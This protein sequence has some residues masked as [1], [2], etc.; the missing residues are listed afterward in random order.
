MK[1]NK[2]NKTQK[3]D[4]SALEEIYEQYS[5]MVNQIVYRLT[6]DKEETRDIVQ[7]IF[8]KIFTKISSFK[9]RSHLK[10]WISRVAVNTVY[11][12]FR[13]KRYRRYLSFEG[14]A[15]SKKETVRKKVIQSEFRDIINDILD[16]L[17]FKHRVVIVMR[18]LQGYSYNEIASILKCSIGTV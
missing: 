10:T 5:G 13:K 11:D 16:K 9:E 8:L 14:M 3:D 4:I 6:R 17:P 2:I 7:D 12:H 15:L 18:E 1:E